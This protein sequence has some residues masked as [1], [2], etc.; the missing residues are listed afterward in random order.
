MTDFHIDEGLISNC[1]GCGQ[2]HGAVINT[3]VP[4]LIK[5]RCMLMFSFKMLFLAPQ[6]PENSMRFISGYHTNNTLLSP[7]MGLHLCLNLQR[8]LSLL[9]TG[10]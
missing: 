2:H 4:V 6:L 10:F 8:Q 7:A 3:K 9:M 5:E 1:G